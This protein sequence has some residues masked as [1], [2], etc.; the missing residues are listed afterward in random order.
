MLK[1]KDVT[2][3]QLYAAFES[4]KNHLTNKME[5]I[6][7]L[8]VFPVPD[9]DTGTNMLATF[10]SGFESI[11]D[12]NMKTNGEIITNFAK[13]ALFGARGN[14]GVILSQIIRGFKDSWQNRNKITS[15]DIVSALEHAVTRA[16]DSVAKPVEGTILTFIKEVYKIVKKKSNSKTNILDL[17]ALIVKEG[18]KICDESPKKL[19][20]LSDAGVTDSGSEGMLVIFEGMYHYFLEGNPIQI[21][22]TQPTSIFTFDTKAGH[23]EFGYCTEVIVELSN[24]EGFNRK[25]LESKLERRIKSLVIVEQDGV[26]KIHGHTDKPGNMLN[27]LQK[28]GEFAKIKIESMD[29][30]ADQIIEKKQQM[31]KKLAMSALISCNNGQGFYEIMKERHTSEVI[32]FDKEKKPSFKD[33]SDAIEKIEAKSFFILPNEKNFLLVANQVAKWYKKDNRAK[34]IIIMPSNNQ[35]MGQYL[36]EHFHPDTQ[37]KDN[38]TFMIE[39]SKRI[40][41]FEIFIASKD[42]KVN[43]IS[44]KKG[45]FC[46]AK[47]GKIVIVANTF[48]E[49]S[50]QV[51]QKNINDTTF[52][53]YLTYGKDLSTQKIAQLEKMIQDYPDIDFLVQQGDQDIYH[54][55]IG[56]INE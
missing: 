52:S 36:A 38:K 30:Q 8:N 46:A 21:S 33:F 56:I 6:N 25:K 15:L 45:Q 47:D 31:P 14:S 49:I 22:Q 20:A 11:K 54:L 44:V 51:L 18:R 13:G 34:K 35:L 9:G 55:L 29:K 3:K 2:A 48:E 10:N 32:L 23:D 27:Y 37:W 41:V 24:S 19:K 53:V 4:A 42:A 26:I 12:L 40:S 1:I 16:Y 43:G 7:S 50:K 17:F 39:A 5:W 28:F